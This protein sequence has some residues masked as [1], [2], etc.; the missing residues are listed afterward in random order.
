LLGEDE[1]DVDGSAVVG[2]TVGPLDGEADGLF[3]GWDVGLTD[4][5]GVGCE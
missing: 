4:G 2:E 3:D 1:G 5:G